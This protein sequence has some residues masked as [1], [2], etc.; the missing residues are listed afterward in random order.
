MVAHIDDNWMMEKYKDQDWTE[1]VAGKWGRFNNDS[2]KTYFITSQCLTSVAEGDASDDQK[3]SDSAYS[4]L[5]PSPTPI[6]TG[7]PTSFQ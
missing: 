6:D 7:S 1:S 4:A 3:Q 2:K 5:S